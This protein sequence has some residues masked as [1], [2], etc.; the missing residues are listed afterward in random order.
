VEVKSRATRWATDSE[1]AAAEQA[2]P[3]DLPDAVHVATIQR[4]TGLSPD[5]A[6]L[7]LAIMRGDSEGD[8]VE[9]AE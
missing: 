2:F 3:R 4:Q 1:I 7:A 6:R 5:T 8:C 9:V